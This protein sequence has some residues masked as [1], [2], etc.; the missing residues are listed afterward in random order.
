MLGLTRPCYPSVRI[1]L[2]PEGR[3]GKP[4]IHSTKFPLRCRS[5]QWL[6]QLW[7][8]LFLWTWL[9]SWSS[10]SLSWIDSSWST[11]SFLLHQ[12]AFMVVSYPFPFLQG[13]S[14]ASKLSST[15][16]GVVFV[17]TSLHF[18]DVGKRVELSEFLAGFSPSI[19][20]AM[21]SPSSS[22]VDLIKR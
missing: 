5:R 2:S 18:L 4:A 16:Q 1:K 8:N 10:L 12:P 3:K 6:E 9:P 15:A 22:F 20:W 21:N 17:G 13:P 7:V 14:T 11:L 19:K